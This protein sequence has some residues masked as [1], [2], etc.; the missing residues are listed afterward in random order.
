MREGLQSD[1]RFAE[2][3]VRGRAGKGYGIE[4]IRWELRQ[5]GIGRDAEPDFGEWD[6][7]GLVGKVYCKKYGDTLPDSPAEQAARERFLLHRGFGRD[8]I[9]RLF[10]RLRQG[11]DE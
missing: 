7:D 8:D 3:Y 2:A 5:R 6:W 4:R 11:G 9:R 10:R 1:A